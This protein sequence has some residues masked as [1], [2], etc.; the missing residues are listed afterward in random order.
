[1]VNCEQPT[2]S[3]TEQAA[4]R[5]P[6]AI[7]GEIALGCHSENGASPQVKTTISA[8]TILTKR[9][10]IAKSAKYVLCGESARPQYVLHDDSTNYLIIAVDMMH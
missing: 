10:V 4:L 6:K 5:S 9:N 8:D 2:K 3:A 1:L 7:S